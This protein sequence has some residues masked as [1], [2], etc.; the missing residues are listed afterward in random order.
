MVMT[1]EERVESRLRDAKLYALT[2]LK[3][4]RG[5]ALRL[6]KVDILEA[7]ISVY[8]GEV[9]LVM[10]FSFEEG[11]SI[12]PQLMKPRLGRIGL[13]EKVMIANALESVTPAS[14]LNAWWTGRDRTNE[15]HAYEEKD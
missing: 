10:D 11:E 8:Y 5:R 1:S 12:R 2:V 4:V 15:V 14:I 9:F 13:T 3:G 6:R 7:P